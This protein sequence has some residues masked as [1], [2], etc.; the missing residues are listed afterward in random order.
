ML[1]Q[2]K[3]K[4]FHALLMA[5]SAKLT[6]PENI[7][8]IQKM[9]EVNLDIARRKGFVGIFATNT[10]PLT[11]Q[12]ASDIYGYRT[13]I[14]CQ[15]NKYVHHDGSKPFGM[16]ADSQRVLVHWKNITEFSG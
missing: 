4:V 14:N 5:T 10:S 7:E 13:L 16:A 11:Q 12:L 6:P 3:H 9:E 2:G 1:P 15:I 8:A